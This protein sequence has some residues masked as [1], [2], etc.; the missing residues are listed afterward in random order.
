MKYHFPET[1]HV[2]TH[3]LLTQLEHL[4]SECEEII[5]RIN[6]EDFVGAVQETLDMIHSGETFLRIAELHGVDL[7][8]EK[9]RVIQ[10]N[11]K[12]GYY[13]PGKS[14]KRCYVENRHRC[15]WEG[16]EFMQFCR[17][18]AEGGKKENCPDYREKED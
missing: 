11:K 18:L 9:R 12:R 3:G 15:C 8:A 10:K 4:K 2:R 14:R 7:A 6:S 1:V 5:E 17:H 16:T 13:P